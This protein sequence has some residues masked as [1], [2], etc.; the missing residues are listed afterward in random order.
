MKPLKEISFK[1]KSWVSVNL[2]R[3]SHWKTL[4]TLKNK[5][6]KRFRKMLTKLMNECQFNTPVYVHI[7]KRNRLDNDNTSGKYFFDAM[8][9]LNMIKS[10]APKYVKDLRI[11][12]NM[13]IP[14]DCYVIRFYLAEDDEDLSSLSFPT[15]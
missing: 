8:Q 1:Y 15:F 6:R 11:T 7:I 12:H 14:S 5:E 10:D 2:M 4:N 3:D 9:D 13:T